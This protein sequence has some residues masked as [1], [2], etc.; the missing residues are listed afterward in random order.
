MKKL[1]AILATLV[2]ATTGWAYDVYSQPD[3][4][5]QDQRTFVIAF[6]DYEYDL[7]P[8][9]YS[10]TTES[11]IIVGLYEGLF[12]Y[13][14]VNLKPQYALC[15][16]Y[17]ISR[18][19]KRWTFTIRD[20]AKFSD[21]TPITAQTFRDS[22]I[23]L[24]SNPRASFASMLDCVTGAKDFRLGKGREEDVRISAK[25][26][27]TLVIYLD[28]AS[29]HLPSVLCHGAFSAVSNKKNVYSGPFVLKSVDKKSLEMVRNENY[30]DAT[31]VVVPG[32]KI[33]KSNDE[34]ENTHLYNTG[35]VDWVSTVG[36]GNKA[37]D[38]KSVRI[39]TEFATTYLFFKIKNKPW[40]HVEFR[41]ALLEAVPYDQIRKGLLIPARNFVYPLVDYPSVEGL[42]DYDA[43]D[44]LVMMNQAREKYGVPL[45]EKIPLII[46]VDDVGFIGDVAKILKSAWEPLGV[47]VIVQTTDA[48]SYNRKIQSWNADIFVYSWVGDYADPL[49]MLELFRSDSTLNES[50]YSS[51]IFDNYLNQAAECDKM[52]Q[53][54]EFLSKAEEKL[55]SDAVVIPLYHQVSMNL[56]SDESIGGWSVN[57]LDLHPLKNLYI[58]RKILYL[59]NLI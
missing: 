9:T 57:P 51:K 40:N 44:A 42:E 24:L 21:G 30:W 29:S 36:D 1:K 34:K 59:P 47:N 25:D 35:V 32:I 53:R 20:G 55:L 14:P 49:A 31:S 54:Y 48:Y 17:K 11:Q 28:K 5:P 3:F 52:T 45:D 18:D 56:L 50:K 2:L 13:N 16:S 6:P 39:G 8:H 15:T 41:R 23:S 46:A 27:K 26:E 38:E 7:N 37:I 19:K 4:Y 33:I 58:K 10:Y 12:S 43:D 22:W